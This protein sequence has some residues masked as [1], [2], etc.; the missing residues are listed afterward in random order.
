MA[1]N[2]NIQP[3][4]EQQEPQGTEQ[5]ETDW[6]AEA[7]KWEAR[8]KKSAEAEKELAALKA[9]QMTEQEKLQARA[10]QAESELAALKAE[11]ERSNAAREVSKEY[12]VPVSLLEYCKD[13]DSMEQF[14]KEY[15]E[16]RTETP[17][18]PKAHPT[19]LVKEHVHQAENR[20]IFA[21][22]MAERDKRA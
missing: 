9:A 11:A 4:E 3:I 2:E 22:Y 8:A 17:V 10:E 6:K 20:D 18:A 19:R 1:D 15:A 16:Q 13:R 12:D 7:R 14:A 5:H 21:A